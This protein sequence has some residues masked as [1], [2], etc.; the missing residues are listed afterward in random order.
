MTKE[1]KRAEAPN[2]NDRH[3][4]MLFN[5]WDAQI[6]NAE[7]AVE[8]AATAASNIIDC[9]N[10]NL[11]KENLISETILRYLPQAQQ[12]QTEWKQKAQEKEK[13][14]KGLT[15]LNWDSY[16][17]CLV[18]PHSQCMT[19]NCII[20]SA[21]KIAPALTNSVFTGQLK[22]EVGQPNLLKS[23]MNACNFKD[24]IHK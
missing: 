1:G 23:M 16:W 2:I 18:K 12:L 13:S 17:A 24:Q 19:L 6:K 7:Q 10:E 4:E 21:E 8:E 9:V 5:N 20:N 22:F 15:Q 11:H 14:I 3:K